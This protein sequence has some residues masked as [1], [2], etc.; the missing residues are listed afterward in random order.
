MVSYHN[1]LYGVCHVSTTIVRHAKTLI[2]EHVSRSMYRCALVIP[3][4]YYLCYYYY[5]YYYWYYYF[6][7]QYYY[8]YYYYYD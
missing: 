8:Y 5:Y 1:V 4:Q 7:Y 2:T 3:H 6:Y